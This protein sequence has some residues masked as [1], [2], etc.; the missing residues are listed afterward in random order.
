MAIPDSTLPGL[1]SLH[2]RA[3]A[4]LA[5]CIETP[6]VDFKGPATWSDI[7]A[8]LLKTIMGMANIRDGGIIIVGLSEKSQQ[9]E[10]V[11]ISPE[12]LSTYDPDEIHDSV[13][14]FAAP[15]FQFEVATFSS[16]EAK[17]FLV[18]QVPEFHEIPIICRKDGEINKEVFCKGDVYIRPFGGRARTERI[19][20]I[21][22]M[23]DL[24]ELAAEKKMRRF[25]EQA[26]RIGYAPI[27]F[28]DDLF[29]KERGDL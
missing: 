20:S 8:K 21:E 24:L 22:E 12:L 13:N 5:R 3:Q 27:A 15:G 2:V 11:G 10:P 25:A 29:R 28:D 16:D 7:K 18:I 9:W 1:S 17:V 6:G 14:K 26:K 19:Q 23:R 4:A